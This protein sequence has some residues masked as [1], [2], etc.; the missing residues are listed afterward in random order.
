MIYLYNG[1][2]YF[3]EKLQEGNYDTDDTNTESFPV[4]IAKWNNKNG[5]HVGNC[6]GHCMC[7]LG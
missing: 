6:D 7:H 5:R 4:C 1:V 3:H 2:L